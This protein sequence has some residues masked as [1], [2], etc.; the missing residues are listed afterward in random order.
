VLG[1]YFVDTNREALVQTEA[2]IAEIRK[3]FEAEDRV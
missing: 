2:Q 3:R 1:T